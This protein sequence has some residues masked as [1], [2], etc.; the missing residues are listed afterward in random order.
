MPTY[1]MIAVIV[2]LPPKLTIRP[3]I[4]GIAALVKAS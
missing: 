3:A 1:D 2:D 4:L